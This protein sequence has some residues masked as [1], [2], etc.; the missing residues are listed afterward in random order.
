M[1]IDQIQITPLN[2][3]SNE[4]TFSFG[5]WN[6]DQARR[7]ESYEATKMVNRWPNILAMITEADPDIL[8]L[9]EL[10][11]LDNCPIQVA[12]ILY[13]IAKLGYDYKHAYYGPRKVSFALATFYKRD[14]LYLSAT[15][16]DILPQTA[17]T[18]KDD[19]KILLGVTLRSLKTNRSFA[20]F[21]THLDLD[22]RNKWLSVEN[23]SA[24][25]FVRNGLY[26]DSEGNQLS[27]DEKKLLCAGDFNFFDDRDGVEQRNHMLFLYNDLAYPLLNASGTFMGF[28]QDAFKKPYDAMS[29][30]DHIFSKG[31]T[32]A[33][34]GA[35]VA[36]DLEEIKNRTY[37]SDHLMIT[38][39]FS[40]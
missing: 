12:D 2:D 3:D 29:R 26:L 28:K 39:S 24:L 33:G 4:E 36:G 27:S 23:L 20:V 9:Q 18:P 15:S 40:L 30:L 19:T 16:I 38:V 5:T 34:K 7:E 17:E 11:N 10:R 25:I 6:I 32:L 37:P 35:S 1:E 14:R 21:N 22:E 13:Q 8:C 31:V